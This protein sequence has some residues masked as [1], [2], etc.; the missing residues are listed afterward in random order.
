MLHTSYEL[1][2]SIAKILTSKRVE[3][4]EEVHPPGSYFILPQNP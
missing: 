3:T 4:K 1:A 2:Q